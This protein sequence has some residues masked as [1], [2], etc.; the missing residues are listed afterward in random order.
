MTYKYPYNWSERIQPPVTFILFERFLLEKSQ[1]LKSNYHISNPVAEKN[2]RKIEFGHRFHHSHWLTRNA[3]DVQ[4]QH[5]NFV[6]YIWLTQV[7]FTSFA[8]CSTHALPML[9]KVQNERCA[10]KTQITD[11][12]VKSRKKIRFCKRSSSCDLSSPPCLLN[13]SQIAQLY[14]EYG[15]S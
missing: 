2:L 14:L 13:I 1:K 7:E 4:I 9:S 6:T 10:R 11:N 15:K 12:I 8:M 5:H 3:F